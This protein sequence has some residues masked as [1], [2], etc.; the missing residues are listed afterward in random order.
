MYAW[1]SQFAR[2]KFGGGGG[3]KGARSSRRQ[4]L[5]SCTFWEGD[6][7]CKYLALGGG[8]RQINFPPDK[9]PRSGSVMCILRVKGPWLIHLKR[10]SF[11]PKKH[12]WDYRNISDYASIYLKCYLYYFLNHAINRFILK[13]RSQKWDQVHPADDQFP[14]PF[15]FDK[16]SLFI[17]N[18]L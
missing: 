3:A 13:K 16:I 11:M 10:I 9:R 12:W 4:I 6:I 18:L 7:F 5:R 8:G 17:E 1:S 14:L 15:S 2:V